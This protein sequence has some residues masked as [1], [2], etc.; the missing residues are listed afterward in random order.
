MD[1]YVSKKIDYTKMNVSMIKDGFIKLI[2]NT[3]I[4]YIA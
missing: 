1:G 4:W 3:G 2:E